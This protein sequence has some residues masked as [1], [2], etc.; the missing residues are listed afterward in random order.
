VRA[1]LKIY[2]VPMIVNAVKMAPR[3]VGSL[4]VAVTLCLA[5]VLVAAASILGL[6][7]A[8]QGWA[9]SASSTTIQTPAAGR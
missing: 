9:T 4:F 7:L 5:V 8:V 1:I 3:F 2:G 6:T